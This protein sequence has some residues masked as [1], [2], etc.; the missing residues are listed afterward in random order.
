ML[1]DKSPL[2]V[3]RDKGRAT[4]RWVN[5]NDSILHQGDQ[6]TVTVPMSDCFICNNSLSNEWHLCSKQINKHE[7]VLGTRVQMYYYRKSGLLPHFR[8]GKMKLQLQPLSYTIS[9]TIWTISCTTWTSFLNEVKPVSTTTNWNIASRNHCDNL[10]FYKDIYSNW[11]SV[12]P[13]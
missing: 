1:K 5:I 13:T 7:H 12:S 3:L 10:I 8:W 4:K 6:K 11:V 2:L 9:C